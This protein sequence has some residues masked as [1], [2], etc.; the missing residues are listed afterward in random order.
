MNPLERF[1]RSDPAGPTLAAP[2][3]Q[4]FAPLHVPRRHLHALHSGRMPSCWSDYNCG[5]PP[6]TSASGPPTHRPAAT[7]GWPHAGMVGVSDLP[8]PAHPSPPVWGVLQDSPSPSSMVFNRVRP[9]WLQS[10][11]APPV[12]ERLI[13]TTP[14]IR[15]GTC[16]PISQMYKQRLRE[17][18]ALSRGIQVSEAVLVS[19]GPL[20]RS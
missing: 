11:Q 10:P 4:A 5:Q 12:P 9:A 2:P 8:S 17:C 16:E 14:G 20:G 7:S 18:R 13:F 6:G 19:A 15:A 3:P 1:W